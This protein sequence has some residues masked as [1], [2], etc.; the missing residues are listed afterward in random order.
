MCISE[1]IKL[2]LIWSLLVSP[3]AVSSKGFVPLNTMYLFLFV[4]EKRNENSKQYYH[5]E[6]T[7]VIPRKDKRVPNQSEENGCF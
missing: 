1:F 5:L 6:V 3:N 7:F 2:V 4:C